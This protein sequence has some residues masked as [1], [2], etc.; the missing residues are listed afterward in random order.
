MKPIYATC[1]RSED[2]FMKEKFYRIASWI[3]LGLATYIPVI[4]WM[5]QSNSNFQQQWGFTKME[6]IA[7]FPSCLPH[8]MFGFLANADDIF[9]NPI[10]LLKFLLLF[11]VPALLLSG[12]G[13]YKHQCEKVNLWTLKIAAAISIFA[14]IICVAL[15]Y[16]SF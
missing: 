16:V 15:L 6:C 13:L 2:D 9:R 14:I 3:G 1:Q 4:V 7:N 5:L 10:T 8:L 11:P 12:F